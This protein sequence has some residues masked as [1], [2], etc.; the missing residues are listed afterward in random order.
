MHPGVLTLV[1]FLTVRAVDYMQH[2]LSE[3]VWAVTLDY[4]TP[5]LRSPSSGLASM[6]PWL[7]LGPL[8]Q[9]LMPTRNNAPN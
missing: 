9:L 8:A 6:G 3:A 5:L 2:S 7:A 1:T 4:V